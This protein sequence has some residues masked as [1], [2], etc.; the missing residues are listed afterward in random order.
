MP[1]IESAIKRV[2]TTEK[3][4]IQNA[5]QVSKMRTNIKKFE[6]AV[7]AGADN[8]QDLYKEAIRSIDIAASK[9]LIHKN[10]ANRDKARL[11]AKLAK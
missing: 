3:A 4:T 11:S 2:R 10:K 9:K 7:A 1:N 5:A 6:A 8:A